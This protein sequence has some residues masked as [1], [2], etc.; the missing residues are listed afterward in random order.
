LIYNWAKDFEEGIGVVMGDIERLVED[1]RKII[2]S[3][4]P[5]PEL[6]EQVSLRLTTFASGTQWFHDL[7][8][9]RLFDS[10]FY[11]SQL[12]SIW[13]NELSLFHSPDYSV[14]MYF[15]EPGY[16]DI[17]H[18]HGSWGVITPFGQPFSERKYKRLD[19]GNQEGYA[20]LEEISFRIV[21]P[22][23]STHVLPLNDGIHRI[24]NTSQN[25]IASVN[26]YGR[27]YRHGYV[28]FYDMSKRK[29]W[30]AYPPRSFKQIMLIK[31]VGNIS[32]PW[33]RQLLAEALKKDLPG[34]IKEQCQ[35]SLEQR[36][37][38]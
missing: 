8:E 31:A 33:V 6:F 21:K 5:Q 19:G 18:D 2:N 3:G 15:W 23:D 25:F 17:I 36:S 1:L 4:L 32:E 30:R 20:E 12:N 11:A 29:V 27:P 37:N 24:E 14:L 9:S 7:V 13:P 16:V 35:L 26:V 38:R 28:Q 10:A 22:G 34:H